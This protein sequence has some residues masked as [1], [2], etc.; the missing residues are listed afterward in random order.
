MKIS[1]VRE[2][3]VAV[4]L[5]LAG[6]SFAATINQGL[7]SG[8]LNT[9]EDQD[10]EAFVDADRSGTLSLGDVFIGFVRLDNFLPRGLDTNNQ[11]YAVITNQ[12]TGL[13]GD[14]TDST[15]LTLGTT[16]VAGLRLE[17]LTGNA[18]TAGGMFAVYDRSTPF[19]TNLINGAPAGATSMFDYIDMITGQGTLRLVAGIAAAD[20]YLHVDNATGLGLGTPTATFPTLATSVTVNSYVG[21]FSIVYNNTAFSYE[22]AVQTLGYD[23]AV[24]VNQLGIGNGA[25]RGQAGEGNES[26]WGAAPGFTQCSVPN[27]GGV[28]NVTCG[29]VTDADFFVQPVAVPEPGSLALLGAGLLGVAGARRARR[30]AGMAQA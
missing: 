25:T 7:T 18:P 20:D 10:R 8:V 22:D 28:D 4:G 9:V 12:I 21:G 30:K 6:T 5:A 11:V 15:L 3:V 26:L 27:N 24:Y 29:F 14:G 16:T 2:L 13:V 23:G 19:D 1:R 17:D